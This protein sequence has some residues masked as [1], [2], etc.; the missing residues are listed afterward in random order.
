LNKGKIEAMTNQ[1]YLSKL[2][3]WGSALI[4]LLITPFSFDPLNVSKFAFLSIFGSAIYSLIL[5][6]EGVFKNLHYRWILI[7]SGIFVLLGFIALLATRANLL[8]QLFGASGRHTGF[9]TY[10]AL[11]GFMLGAALV[12]NKF[13]LESL[14]KFLFVSGLVSL[15]YGLIQ[16]FDLDPLNWTNSFSPV[17]GFLGNPNFQS[18]FMAI[19]STV[20]FSMILKSST[21]LMLKLGYSVYI[22]LALFSIYKSNSQQGFL[23]FGAGFLVV[24]LFWTKAKFQSKGLTS[25]YILTGAGVAIATV[26]DILQKTPWT[27]I[28]YKESVSNR[29]DLWRA[30]WRMTLD[31]P[32]FGVGFDNYGDWYRRYRDTAAISARGVDTI[33]NTAHNVFLDISTSG[34]ILLLIA[35]LVILSFALRATFKLFMRTKSFDAPLAGIIGAWFAYLAQSLISINQIG[36]AI[37]GW[38]FSGAIIGYEIVTRVETPVT[39]RKSVENLGTLL[40]GGFLGMI[41]GLPPLISDVVYRNA[42]DSRQVAAVEK[43]AY[44]WPQNGDRMLQVAATLRDNKLNDQALKVARDA[45]KFAPERYEAWQVL[46][47]I[48]TIPDAEKAQAYAKLKELDPYNPN[49]K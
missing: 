11:T 3:L 40:I 22:S 8:Q 6:T 17:I 28:L 2:V 43:S 29:G 31:H 37:W 33:S 13:F 7:T 26:L 1:K 23:V 20:V 19:T 45:T 10:L 12:S 39:N 49:L 35:Y 48:P 32:I 9:L 15:S 41:I 5:T 14:S 27:S 42:I 18:S 46:G 36:L 24:L 47:S 4:S 16:V 30:G 34:G 44:Q 25:A 38:V 21:K